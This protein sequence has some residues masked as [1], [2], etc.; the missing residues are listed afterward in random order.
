VRAAMQP[1]A[2]CEG[3]ISAMQREML[4]HNI[5]AM[6]IASLFILILLFLALT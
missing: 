2:S 1:A 6:M 5:T 3:L 4:T